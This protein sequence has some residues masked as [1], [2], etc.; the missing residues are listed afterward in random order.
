MNGREKRGKKCRTRERK[1]EGTFSQKHTNRQLVNQSVSQCARQSV[2]PTLRQTNLP[3]RWPVRQSDTFRQSVSHSVC[4]SLGLSICQSVGYLVSQSVHRSVCLSICQL[5]DRSVSQSNEQTKRK[6]VRRLIL[7]LLVQKATKVCVRFQWSDVAVFSGAWLSSVRDTHS[8]IRPSRAT[9]CSSRPAGLL[10]S[11]LSTKVDTVVFLYYHFRWFCDTGHLENPSRLP[12]EPAAID[13]RSLSYELAAAG[14][15]FCLISSLK[16]SLVCL[17]LWLRWNP[18]AL[19][20]F[21][22]IAWQG[23]IVFCSFYVHLVIQ[24]SFFPVTHAS[25]L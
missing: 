11:N 21:V 3:T 25:D 12:R 20:S 1:K 14:G 13:Y 24:T 22:S 5:I 18:D 17:A 15:V 6:K 16:V 9:S 23:H 19:N 10:A 4:L 7:I 2:R 8:I